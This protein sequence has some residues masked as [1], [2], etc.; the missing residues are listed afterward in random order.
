M[1]IWVTRYALTIGTSVH[2][3][4]DGTDITGTRIPIQDPQLSTYFPKYFHKPYWHTSR[5]AA[6][7]HVKALLAKARKSLKTQMEKLDKFEA[8][9]QEKIP[10]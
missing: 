3:V 8:S 7:E 6:V 9:Y 2:E 1:R 4:P 5:E 10:R